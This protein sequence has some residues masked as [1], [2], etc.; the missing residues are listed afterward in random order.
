MGEGSLQLHQQ[1]QQPRHSRRR[2]RVQ[3]V[4]KSP[5][6]EPTQHQ[7]AV[8]SRRNGAMLCC[9]G[10]PWQKTAGETVSPTREQSSYVCKAQTETETTV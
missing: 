7:E 10:I 9:V 5:H 8:G 2:D 6:V 3:E 4:K 1:H